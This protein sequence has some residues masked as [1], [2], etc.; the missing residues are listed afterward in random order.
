V[1]DRRS[2]PFRP[3]G[4]ALIAASRHALGMWEIQER[5][6]GAGK[7]HKVAIVA[8]MRKMVVM[9]NALLRDRRE[10]TPPAPSRAACG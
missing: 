10:W 7:A 3:L 8:V 6:V 2:R 9:M 1:R 4:P 5:P